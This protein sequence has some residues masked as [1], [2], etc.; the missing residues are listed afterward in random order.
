MI[1]YYLAFQITDKNINTEK[2]IFYYKLWNDTSWMYSYMW[3]T[4]L[5]ANVECVLLM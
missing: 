2:W 1:C 5:K 3:L 4:K